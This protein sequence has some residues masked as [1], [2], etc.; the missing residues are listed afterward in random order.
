MTTLITFFFREQ[1]NRKGLNVV[2]DYDPSRV[3]APW[4]LLSS[5]GKEPSDKEMEQYAKDKLKQMEDRK[6]HPER[7]A[8]GV[9]SM[10]QPDSLE[11]I[12]DQK[13]RWLFSFFTRTG[14]G[15]KMMPK[16]KGQLAINKRGNFLEWMDVRTQK[17]RKVAFASKIKEFIMYCE[18][19]LAV[20]G[21]AVPTGCEFRIHVSFG[22]FDVADEHTLENY[23]DYR[24]VDN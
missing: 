18:F 1:V 15:Q 3:N 10:V 21:Q 8:L 22:G 16:M 9:K 12:D 23:S 2:G 7:S 4:V 24:L 14:E 13:D 17:P 5:D 6:K 19:Q 20:D 11:L